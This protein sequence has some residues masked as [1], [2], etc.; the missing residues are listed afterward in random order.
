MNFYFKNP[1]VWAPPTEQRLLAVLVPER[2][3]EIGSTDRYLELLTRRVD[4]LIQQWMHEQEATQTETEAL[5][6]QTLSALEPNQSAPAIT[7]AGELVS[8]HLW[9]QAWGRALTHHNGT[10]QAK[11]S[12]Q[13]VSFP[14]TVET[15]PATVE[16]LLG[17]FQT[18]DTQPNL[19]EWLNELVAQ[20]RESWM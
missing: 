10:V 17:L 2:E 16:W 11:L 6:Y 14:T 19:E 20:P 5:L 1:H 9:Q 7:A 15:D 3:T 4:W 13:A 18:E 8:L 12:L